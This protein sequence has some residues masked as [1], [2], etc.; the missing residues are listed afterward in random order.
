[1]E[2]DVINLQGKNAEPEPLRSAP[3]FFDVMEPDAQAAACACILAFGPA[4]GTTRD[5]RG[6]RRRSFRVPSGPGG[7][8][9]GPL[10]KYVKH[11]YGISVGLYDHFAIFE[12]PDVLLFAFRGTDFYDAQRLLGRELRHSTDEVKIEMASWTDMLRS[13]AKREDLGQMSDCNA[14]HYIAMKSEEL[15]PLHNACRTAFE[16]YVTHTRRHFGRRRVIVAGASLGGSLAAYVARPGEKIYLF[17]PAGTMGPKPSWIRAHH[18][19]IQSYRETFDIV[20]LSTTSWWPTISATMLESSPNKRLMFH[21]LQTFMCDTR[22][23]ILVQQERDEPIDTR[24]IS[25][26]LTE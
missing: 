24:V 8:L 17:S 4:N 20:S 1:M 19:D 10:W 13:C 16:H 9:E 3:C 5:T 15:S 22:Y 12:T 11:P 23:R 14:N 7:A 26:Q 18:R 2:A 21:A 25:L 6:I